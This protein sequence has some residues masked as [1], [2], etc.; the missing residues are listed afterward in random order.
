MKKLGRYLLYAFFAWSIVLL[1]S[2]AYVKFSTSPYVYTATQ[3]PVKQTDILIFGNSRAESAINDKLLPPKF[4]NVA[5]SGEALFYSTIKARAIL[6]KYGNDTVIIEFT[7]NSLTTI[8]WVLDDD[9]LYTEYQESFTR[10]Q[11]H[12]HLFLLRHKPAK[13]AKTM[14]A[15]SPLRILKTYRLVD[16]SYKKLQRNNLINPDTAD[17]STK[18]QTRY[19]E[20]TELANFDALKNLITAF[21]HTHFIITRTPLHHT[22]I[23]RNEET[24]LL[25]AHQLDQLPNCTFI[26][27]HRILPRLPDSCFADIGH[28][29][30]TG[31][32]IY[33]PIFLEKIRKPQSVN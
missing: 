33:T 28:L 3:K 26:D 27:F 23:L 25:R 31:A 11:L 13:A 12:E 24:F 7:N 29:N 6:E 32:G 20:S 15:M 19:D 30:H 21:P 9:R 4:H 18:P 16:G 17:N 5:S 10:M 2:M 1:A 22:Y 14:L 8:K